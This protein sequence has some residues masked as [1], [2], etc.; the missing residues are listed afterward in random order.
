MENSDVNV[1]N[2]LLDEL[3]DFTKEDVA[4]IL[5]YMGL[6]SLEDKGLVETMERYIYFSGDEQ[7]VYTKEERT[8]ISIIDNV[9]IYNESLKKIENGHIPCRIIATEFEYFDELKGALFFMKEINKAID[10]FNL[11]IIKINHKVFV[12]MRMFDKDTDCLLSK[13]LEY[14]KDFSEMY[15]QLSFVNNSDRFIDYYQSLL[16]ALDD[17]KD[18]FRD[19]DQDVIIR[20]GIQ[21]DYLNELNDIG[22]LY[23]LDFTKER[24]RYYNSFD[25]FADDNFYAKVKEKMSD[26]DF[27]KSTKTNSMEL[28]FDAEEML[29]MSRKTYETNVKL[30]DNLHIESEDDAIEE[31]SDYMDDPEELIK[32]LRKIKGI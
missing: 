31:M 17:S 26:L 27:I 30:E 12:G 20:K 1:N 21:Y 8:F 10:G 11:F 6:L 9:F 19:Y 24:E 22:N 4:K 3:F 5:N 16:L 25:D 13:P 2:L 7:E 15:G 14:Y 23:D 29:E 32:H 28:L 18:C